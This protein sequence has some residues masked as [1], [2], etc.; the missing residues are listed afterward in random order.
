MERKGKR[1]GEEKEEI[2]GEIERARTE[3]IGE[4]GIE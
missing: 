3:I 2:T 4:R 1:D